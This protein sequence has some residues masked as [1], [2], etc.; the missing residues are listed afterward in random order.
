MNVLGDLVWRPT[1]Q[2][3]D[4]DVV[5]QVDHVAVGVRST[6]IEAPVIGAVP[7]I[8]GTASLAGQRDG[9]ICCASLRSCVE[10]V[11][12]V[13]VQSGAKYEEQQNNKYRENAYEKLDGRPVGQLRSGILWAA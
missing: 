9:D 12:S 7:T 10:G 3:I 6:A 1:S 13:W 8:R 11:V 5:A 2:T 4:A